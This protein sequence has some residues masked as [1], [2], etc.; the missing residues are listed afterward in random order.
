MKLIEITS[1]TKPQFK[2]F[3]SLLSSKGIKE[4]C[5]FFFCGHKLI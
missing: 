3:K 4:N 5:L 2:I 1:A